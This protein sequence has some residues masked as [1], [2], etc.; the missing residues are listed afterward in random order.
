MASDVRDLGERRMAATRERS[1]VSLETAF[2]RIQSTWSEDAAAA[3]RGAG[4]PSMISSSRRASL[5]MKLDEMGER[6]N[7]A[8][9]DATEQAVA[10]L[11][12]E[13]QILAAEHVDHP[14]TPPV[15]HAVTEVHNDEILHRVLPFFSN[16]GWPGPPQIV[17][18]LRPASLAA[19]PRVMP[20][21]VRRDI[22]QE[23]GRVRTRAL[24]YHERPCGPHYQVA[25]GVSR[26][27]HRRPT[28]S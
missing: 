21:Q 12:R 22:A 9:V 6:Q 4:L 8:V 1:R 11:E 13:A 20:G 26:R 14:N 7:R 2:E 10:E 19:L 17:C 24:E 23:C 5:Q 27:G 28:W 25:L 3:A 15:D 18:P 16:P